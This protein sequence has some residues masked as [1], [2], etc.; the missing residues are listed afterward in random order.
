MLVNRFDERPVTDVSGYLEVTKEFQEKWSR[1]YAYHADAWYRGVTDADKHKLVPS[2]HRFAEKFGASVTDNPDRITES[3]L[4]DEFLR[5]SLPLLR[6]QEPSNK[7]DWYF[8]MQHYDF[9]TRLLDWSE[10]SM[11]GL[12][13]AVYSYSKLKTGSILSL[14][15]ETGCDAAIW[16]L[17]PMSFNKQSLED[18]FSGTEPI[19]RQDNEI[20]SEYLSDRPFALSNVPK[21]PIALM[22]DNRNQRL[23]AQKGMFILFGSDNTPL[24]DYVERDP[25]GQA[26]LVKI[27]IPSMSI[28]G[29]R[30]VLRKAGITPSLYF[31]ELPFLSIDVLQAW[32]E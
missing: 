23:T 20:I 29:I 27:R 25:N 30:R 7:W 17:D 32:C 9:P 14:E 3:D 11:V 26:R 19:L 21:A 22:P 18:R 6:G 31:P 24:E 13:F 16:M 12:F 1:S 15:D 10:S 8:L 28:P 5:R 4:R 2:F